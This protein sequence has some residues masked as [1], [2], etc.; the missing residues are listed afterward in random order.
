LTTGTAA[1]TSCNGDMAMPAPK[2]TVIV[3]SSFQL[4]AR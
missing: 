1:E 2:L 4:D 3:V